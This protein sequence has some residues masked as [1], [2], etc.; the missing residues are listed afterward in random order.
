MSTLVGMVSELRK[1]AALYCT[2]LDAEEER[3]SAYLEGD[4]AKAEELLRREEGWLEE[5]AQSL[6]AIRQVWSGGA[7]LGWSG[8][9]PPD[10]RKA[11]AEA[12]SELRRAAQELRLS[13]GRQARFYQTSE[14]FVGALLQHF[15]FEPS[16]YGT[17]GSLRRGSA[18]GAADVRA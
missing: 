4:L 9:L 17:D 8:E 6:S 16:C 10:Q 12:L 13:L 2:L 3:A 5:A 18:G 7:G 11:L 14:R 15:P 1:L